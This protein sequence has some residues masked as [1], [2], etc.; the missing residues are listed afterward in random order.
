M[1][2]LRAFMLTVP[3]SIMEAAE[4]DGAGPVRVFVS[5]VLP[6]SPQRDHHRRA[7]Q[8]PVRLG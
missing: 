4:V 5:I 3:R 8:L 2:I 1:L 7:V 6:L